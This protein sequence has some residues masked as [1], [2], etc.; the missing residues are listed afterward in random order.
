M[1]S[2]WFRKRGARTGAVKRGQIRSRV[3][4]G[5]EEELMAGPRPWQLSVGTRCLSTSCLRADPEGGSPPNPDPAGEKPKFCLNPK[6]GFQD[7]QSRQKQNPI[8]FYLTH[9]KVCPSETAVLIG[10]KSPLDDDPASDNKLIEPVTLRMAN[11]TFR[12]STIPKQKHQRQQSGRKRNTLI[13]SRMPNTKETDNKTWYQTKNKELRHSKQRTQF[14]L[15]A[16]FPHLP[17]LGKQ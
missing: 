9:G 11:N 6:P 4:P 14:R 13:S 3:H 10:T 5:R 15:F 17:G 7:T 1:G 2:M 8:Q 12:L 16:V